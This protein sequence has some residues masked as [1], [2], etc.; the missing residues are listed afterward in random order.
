M[1]ITQALEWADR[2][3]AP[4]VVERLRSRRVV[5]VLADEVRRRESEYIAAFNAGIE[6]AAKHIES[7]THNYALCIRTLE[8]KP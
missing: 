5:K 2:N 6:A 3:T 4:E 7:D 8:M 1:N